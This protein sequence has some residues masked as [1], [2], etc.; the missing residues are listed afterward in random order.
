VGV[1]NAQLVKEDVVIVER[2]GERSVA[3]QNSFDLSWQTLMNDRYSKL[4]DFL[5]PTKA[6]LIRFRQPVVTLSYLDA[7]I[8]NT[9]LVAPYSNGPVLSCRV[10]CPQTSLTRK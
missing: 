4:R 8:F 10:S 9:R 6:D 5:F 3:E 2:Y 1:S 7:I